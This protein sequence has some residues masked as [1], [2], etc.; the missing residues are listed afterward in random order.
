MSIR[1]IAQD[2]YR[3][4]REVDE[5]ERRLKAAPAGEKEALEDELRKVKAERTRMQRILDG[6]KEPPSYRK[7]R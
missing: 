2:L 4:Q 3:L 6:A 7:P 5:L 1:L